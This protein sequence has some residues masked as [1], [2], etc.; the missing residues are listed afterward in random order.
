VTTYGELPAPERER[1]LAAGLESFVVVRPRVPFTQLF[2]ELQAAN[3]Q[4]AIVGDHMLYSTPYKVYD[5]M[6]AGRP[7]LGLAPRGA[8]LFGL[9]ADSG[10]G[11]CVEPD[12]VDAVE[13]ALEKMLFTPASS[14]ARVDRFRW[15]NLALQYRMAIETVAGGNV[16]PSHDDIAAARK[17]S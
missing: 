11:V 8:A 17:A 10:A 1:I 7:I 12:D 14:T 16:T 9:L 4:I 6:A 5:Y 2:G 13:Q 3:A 15:S